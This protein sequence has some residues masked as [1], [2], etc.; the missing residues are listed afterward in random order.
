MGAGTVKSYRR[1]SMY[2]LYYLIKGSEGAFPARA[3]VLGLVWQ[4][5]KAGPETTVHMFKVKHLAAVAVADLKKSAR[6][7]K[8][9][10]S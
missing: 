3:Q 9:G 5:A 1:T 6:P 2:Q 8:P 10:M 7:V 4:A